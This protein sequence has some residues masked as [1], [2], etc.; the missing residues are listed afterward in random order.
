MQLDLPFTLR[1]ARVRKDALAWLARLRRGLKPHE[2]PEL[3]EW[4]RRR[5]H[6]AGIVR[7]ALEWDCPEALSLLG[8][9]FTIDPRWVRPRPRRSPAAATT[10]ALLAVSLA[11]LP[12]LVAHHNMPGMIL[13][14]PREGSL[15]ESWGDVY[16]ADAAALRRV[17]LADG[18][19]VVMNRGARMA[20]VYSEHMRAALLTRGEA[21]FTVAHE[22]HRPFHLRAGSRNFETLAGS[23]NVRLTGSDALELT[24]LEGQVTVFPAT[25]ISPESAA[26]RA[27]AVRILQPTLL[28]RHQ[29]LDIEAG[30]ESARM[31]SEQ[32]TRSQI[33][34]QQG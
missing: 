32:D 11:A 30:Q 29:V 24:V 23:F 22:P 1:S 20:V 4:L 16:A 12:L 7:A 21:T 25:Q 10:A 33:A 19:R 26:P 13:G 6:R 17:G 18:T 28:G 27:G 14:T 2:G 9:L 8:E 3:L 5:P 31:L 34:W 15:M